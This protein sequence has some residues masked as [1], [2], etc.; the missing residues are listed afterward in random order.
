[1]ATGDLSRRD[2]CLTRSVKHAGCYKG[3]EPGMTLDREAKEY[4]RMF[5]R[6]FGH[7]LGGLTE[8]ER[9]GV[10]ENMPVVT[11]SGGRAPQPCLVT[12]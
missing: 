9:Y 3:G 7:L 8:R 2:L 6:Q 5:S 12:H 11:G 10:V 4:V 1:M